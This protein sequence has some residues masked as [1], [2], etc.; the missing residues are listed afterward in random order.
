MSNQLCD[1][2]GTDEYLFHIHDGEVICD[3]CAEKAYERQQER[4]ME[5]GPDTGVQDRLDQQLRD[6]GRGHLVRP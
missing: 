1:R 5:N 6:A 3:N 4:L 2:C